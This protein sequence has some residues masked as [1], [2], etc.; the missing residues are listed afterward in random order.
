MWFVRQ[1]L[2]G[3][4]SFPSLPTSKPD[5]SYTKKNTSLITGGGVGGVLP[6]RESTFIVDFE[7]TSSLDSH[8][9]RLMDDSILFKK[10]CM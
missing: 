7:P 4:I 5:I 6:S 10:T 9:Q 3:D 2:F 8:D 1:V